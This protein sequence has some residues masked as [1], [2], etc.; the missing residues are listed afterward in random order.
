MESVNY[1]VSVELWFATIA[2]G[3]H[4]SVAVVSRKVTP[5]SAILLNAIKYRVSRGRISAIT[6]MKQREQAAAGMSVFSNDR[7][8]VS[9]SLLSGS[10]L[11]TSASHPLAFGGHHQG[12]RLIINREL[13]GPRKEVASANDDFRDTGRDTT[14]PVITANYIN[15]LAALPPLFRASVR[16]ALGAN[17]ICVGNRLYRLHRR[18]VVPAAKLAWN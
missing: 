15:Q 11:V 17:L 8:L 5:S 2:R 13:T 1:A 3:H 9:T 4:K 16:V 18:P 14:I 6:I 12:A 10:Q 7:E